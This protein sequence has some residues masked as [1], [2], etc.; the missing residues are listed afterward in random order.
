MA[1]HNIYPP[2]LPIPLFSFIHAKH[3]PLVMLVLVAFFQLLLI[4][5]LPYLA[6]TCWSLALNCPFA[7][8]VFPSPILSKDGKVNRHKQ[9]TSVSKQRFEKEKENIMSQRVRVMSH[10]RTGNWR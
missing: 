5:P 2:I 10:N 6:L 9:A 3:C 1:W 8:H 7:F 4:L